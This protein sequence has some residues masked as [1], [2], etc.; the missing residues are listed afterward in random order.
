[1]KNIGLLNPNCKHRWKVYKTTPMEK[2][3]VIRIRYYCCKKCHYTMKTE[4]RSIDFDDDRYLRP[5]TIYL[6]S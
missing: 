6:K 1:M 5:E 2:L 4:E 3:N